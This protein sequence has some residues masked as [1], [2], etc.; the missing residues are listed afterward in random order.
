MSDVRRSIKKKAIVPMP[1]K[2][3]VRQDTHP[4][5]GEKRE[6]SVRL[7]LTRQLRQR[8]GTV[9]EPGVCLSVAPVT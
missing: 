7:L 5:A 1:L 6:L 4:R 9:S 2:V 3:H 8:G